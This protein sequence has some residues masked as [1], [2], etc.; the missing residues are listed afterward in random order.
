MKK[1]YVPLEDLCQNVLK[2]KNQARK[3]EFGVHTQK[4]SSRL[5]VVWLI[6]SLWTSSGTSKT[7]FL[8]T[9]GCKPWQGS[10]TPLTMDA[11]S[12]VGQKTAG[13]GYHRQNNGKLKFDHKLS[14]YVFNAEP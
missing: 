11:L 2:E 3:P 4:L 6:K 5:D 14:I 8:A 12:D 10:S 1:T 9:Q 7:D 13:D